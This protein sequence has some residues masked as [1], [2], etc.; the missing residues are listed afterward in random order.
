MNTIL[1]INRLGLLF[2]RYF[3]ENKQR[4]LTFWGITIFVFTLMHIAGS[5]RKSIS[6]E[7]FLFISGFIFAARTFK[8]FNFTPSGM[9]YLLIP[10]THFEKLTTAIILS[11]FYYFAMILVTYIIGNVLGTILGNLLFDLHNPIQFALF[12]APGYYGTNP[13]YQTSYNPGTRLLNL[14]VVFAGIQAVFMLGSIYFKG[15]SVGKTFLAII[16]ISIVFGLIELFLLRITFGTY[17]LNGQMINFNLN[18]SSGHM[19][20]SQIAK[21]LGSTFKYA[22]I[23]FFWV[24]TYFRLTEKEV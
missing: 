10:A 11:T 14:F 13:I 23:P 19:L 12:Q 20:G 21:V 5:S 17:H 22:L 3:T 4:E 9:H 15:N 24:V 2:K 6:V 1:D 7:M 18:Y 16:A 8:I